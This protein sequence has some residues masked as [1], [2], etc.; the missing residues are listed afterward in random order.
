EMD[1]MVPAQDYQDKEFFFC[2]A[3]GNMVK[4]PNQ[5]NMFWRNKG[6]DVDT[7]N[8]RALGQHQTDAIQNITGRMKMRGNPCAPM[9]HGAIYEAQ[10]VFE[11]RVNQ[12]Q[13]G[14][15]IALDPN[16]GYGDLV[17]F[18]ASKVVRTST[19]TRNTSAA[20]A[21]YIHI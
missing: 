19:E 8:A 4:L 2:E 5:D 9:S 21:P 16:V 11:M 1:L 13:S 12:E 20:T 6:I 17:W 7:A 14:N 10:G 18:D 15:R 3:G